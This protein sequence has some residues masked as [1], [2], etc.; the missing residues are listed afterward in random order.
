MALSMLPLYLFSLEL[1]FGGVCLEK[2]EAN[3][4]RAG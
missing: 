4:G 2:G 1:L 3:A